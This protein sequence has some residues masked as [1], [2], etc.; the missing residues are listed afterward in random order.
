MHADCWF[1]SLFDVR[2]NQKCRDAEQRMPTKNCSRWFIAQKKDWVRE[3][4]KKLQVTSNL[5]I[6]KRKYHKT[7]STSSISAFEGLHG[8]TK[9]GAQTNCQGLKLWH[10]HRIRYRHKNDKYDTLLYL[11]HMH[12]IIQFIFLSSALHRTLF[13][14]PQNWYRTRHVSA[15]R[16]YQSSIY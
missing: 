12:Q 3:R 10:I 13:A 6:R 1:L 2:C 11:K 14:Q 4:E 15:L 16:S 5:F 9:M 8:V 7:N